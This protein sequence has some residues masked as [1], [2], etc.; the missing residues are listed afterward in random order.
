V[1][2]PDPW[3][4]VQE[5]RSGGQA[6][7]FEVRR[8]GDDRRYVLKSLKNVRRSGR[9]EREIEATRELYTEFPWAF[10]EIVDSGWNDDRPFYVMP[11]F[12]S[13]LQDE[14]DGGRYVSDPAAGVARLIELVDAVARLH[15]KG[16]AHRDLKPANVLVNDSGELVLADMGLAIV[17]LDDLVADRDTASDEAVGSRGYLSPE[18]EDGR[19]DGTDHRPSDF[20]AFGKIAWVLLAGRRPLSRERQLEGSNRLGHVLADDRLG[21]VDD[22]CVELLD[23]DPQRRLTNWGTVRAELNRLSDQLRDVAV[24]TP[25]LDTPLAALNEA[26]HTFRRSPLAQAVTDGSERAQLRISQYQALRATAF[27]RSDALEPQASE[28]TT[29]LQ[30]Y[31]QVVRG[32]ISQPTLG[33]ILPAVQSMWPHEVLDETFSEVCLRDGC[34]I[35]VGVD[36]LFTPPTVTLPTPTRMTIA[37]FILVGDADVW[38]LTIPCFTAPDAAQPAAVFAPLVDRCVVL[39]GPSRLGLSTALDQATRLGDKVCELGMH[40]VAEYVG[41]LTQG[42]DLRDPETWRI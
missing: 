15:S 20:Y 25:L 32:S 5:L 41:H 21:G 19:L 22:L 26:A 37:G 23:H 14:V 12:S 3:K 4:I 13:S 39:D 33:R 42:H 31:F 11:W 10:P 38:T 34:A 27:A 28:V 36:C 6:Y 16:W 24:E 18:N 2:L 35:N 17:V 9:F 29:Q 7:L 40:L 8:P 1:A 30:G